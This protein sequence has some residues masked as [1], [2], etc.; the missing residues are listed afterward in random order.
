MKRFT[1]KEEL[2]TIRRVHR[3]WKKSSE[4]I[5]KNGN[6]PSPI[7]TISKDDID[8][9]L[10]FIDPDEQKKLSSAGYE[11]IKKGVQDLEQKISISKLFLI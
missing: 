2:E 8:H 4:V 11:R 6:K 1:K 7:T 9:A 3:M 5:L 10:N